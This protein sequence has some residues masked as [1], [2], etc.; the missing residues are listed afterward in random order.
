[1]EEMFGAGMMY[2]ATTWEDQEDQNLQ[3]ITRH[4][5]CKSQLVPGAMKQD[6]P[7]PA[8]F[9]C[10]KTWRWRLANLIWVLDGRVDPHS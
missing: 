3:P 9:L 2:V 7:G 4:L 5:G 8:M 6:T 10:H 1:M